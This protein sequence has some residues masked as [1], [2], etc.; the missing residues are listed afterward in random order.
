MELVMWPPIED[1]RRGG[2]PTTHIGDPILIQ[3][4]MVLDA[5]IAN[6]NDRSPWGSHF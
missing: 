6:L 3:L 5:N 2:D 1:R 4:W